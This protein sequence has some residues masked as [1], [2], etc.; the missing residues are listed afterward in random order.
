MPLGVFNLFFPVVLQAVL[1]PA[2]QNGRDD[3]AG[4]T[5]APLVGAEAFATWGIS[6]AERARSHG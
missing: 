5:E 1:A 2:N 4:T 6:P 3:G